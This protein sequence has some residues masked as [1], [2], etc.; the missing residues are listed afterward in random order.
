MNTKTYMEG[1]SKEVLQC[2]ICEEGIE[3]QTLSDSD[4]VYWT[5]G[6]NAWPI[7][8]GRC[9]Q[10]CDVNVVIPVRLRMMTANRRRDEKMVEESE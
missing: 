7:N 8:D 5:L 10:W 3:H 1:V 9:C 2:S 6:N 4:E